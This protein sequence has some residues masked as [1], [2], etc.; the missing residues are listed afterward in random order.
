MRK[1]ISVLFISICLI[2]CSKDD[3]PII[4]ARG[5]A[6]CNVGSAGK[7]FTLANSFNNRIL[8]LGN[9]TDELVSLSFPIPSTFPTTYNMDTEDMVT[10]SYVVDGKV[11][12]ATNGLSGVGSIGSLTIQITKYSN[13]K[14]SGTFQFTA[15][16]DSEEQISITQGVFS[17]IPDL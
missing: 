4:L 9:S 14:I 2:S 10:A 7:V 6:T 5:K 11:Y 8:A 1:L 3:N 15:I 17:D 16:S 12:N 13:S